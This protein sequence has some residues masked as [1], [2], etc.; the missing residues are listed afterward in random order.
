MNAKRNTMKRPAY[1]YQTLL[2]ARRRKKSASRLDREKRLTLAKHSKKYVM[3][4]NPKNPKAMKTH[5]ITIIQPMYRLIILTAL[6]IM[7][8]ACDW[9]PE[10]KS[11]IAGEIQQKLQKCD[12][13]QTTGPTK[14]IAFL[15]DR[16]G[17]TEKYG[18]PPLKPADLKPALDYIRKNGGSVMF[19]II[20]ADSDF[21]T[22]QI[23]VDPTKR[24]QKPVKPKREDYKTNNFDYEHD[25]RRYYRNLTAYANRC[26]EYNKELDTQIERFQNEVKELLE[27]DVANNTDIG[28]AVIRANRFHEHAIG[29][30]H[31]TLLISDGE[32]LKGTKVPPPGFPVKCYLV[33][34]K[35]NPTGPWVKTC[36]PEN[37]PDLNTAY[38]LIQI[39]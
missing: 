38:R 4:T 33:Y 19:G 35:N 37:V 22:V 29:N 13:Q 32:D 21:R 26:T 25:M 16:S 17:S 27:K 30:E 1:I 15:Y 28:N 24:P 20:F 12:R 7:T 31:Y 10:R 5:L 11:P 36:Q 14:S 2:R 3:K 18:I 34:G 8:G 6:I 23:T 9:L 39:Q